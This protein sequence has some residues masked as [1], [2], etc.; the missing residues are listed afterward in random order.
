MHGL[1]ERFIGQMAEVVNDKLTAR[2]NFNVEQK[3][4]LT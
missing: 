2:A 1:M 4:E 3:S